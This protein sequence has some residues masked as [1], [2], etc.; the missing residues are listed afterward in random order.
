MKKSLTSGLAIVF[1]S[2]FLF[3]TKAVGQAGPGKSTLHV[4]TTKSK[5][6][7]GAKVKNRKIF[8]LSGY[9]FVRENGTTAALRQISTGFTSGTFT[10]ECRNSGSCDITIL[11]NSINCI[12]NTCSSSCFMTTTI[13]SVV[14]AVHKRSERKFVVGRSQCY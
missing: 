8:A 11:P 10:C 1:V 7:K 5:L 13:K 12:A 6:P 14:I 9:T 2:L 3:S 4:E